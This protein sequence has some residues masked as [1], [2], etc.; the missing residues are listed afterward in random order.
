MTAASLTLACYSAGMIV[1]VLVALWE[2]GRGA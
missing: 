1:I 2:S